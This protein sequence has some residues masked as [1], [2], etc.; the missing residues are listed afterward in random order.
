VNAIAGAG[1]AVRYRLPVTLV[2]LAGVALAA[3][4]N[5]GTASSA[6]SPAG[7]PGP[8]S[9]QALQSVRGAAASGLS[10]TATFTV[11]LEGATVFGR[12]SS[13]RGAGSFDFRAGRGTVLLSPSGTTLH[14]PLVF[15]PQAVY[16]MPPAS[17]ESL[18]SGKTWIMAGFSDTR[19]LTTNLPDFVTEVESLN[20]ALTLSQL[21]W[22]GTAAAPLGTDAV[23]GQRASRYDVT[24]D[25]DQALGGASGAAQTPLAMALQAEIRAQGGSEADGTASPGGAHRIDAQVW[26]GDSGRLLRVQ[27]TPPGAG[28]GRMTLD[29]AGFGTVVQAGIPAAAQVADVAAITP[30]AERENNNGGDSDGA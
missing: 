25:L 4:G 2:A 11:N 23:G 8:S 6:H 30:A 24:V 15:A 22:G 28:V 1:G 10:E 5:V 21:L 17:S 26:V 16:I 19:T 14:E 7:K 29:L 20:P 27:L 18:P 3:C 9:A 12:S 13:V